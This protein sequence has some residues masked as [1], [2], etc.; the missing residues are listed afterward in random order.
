[1]ER[2]AFFREHGWL[3]VRG[4]VARARVEELER[5]LDAVVPPSYYARGLG[6]RV[7]ELPGI[8]RGSAELAAHARD[9]HLARVAAEALGA[10][11]LRL[12]QDSALVKAPADPARVEWHQDFTYL[13]FLEPASIATAR[14][15]LTPCTRESGCLRVLDGSHAWG[16]VGEVRALKSAAVDDA[17][18]LL[19]E[20]L[21]RRAAGAEVVIELEPGD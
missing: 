2:R 11:R 6:G 9:P 7:L 14:L 19:P 10:R 20:E 17:L 4:A 5:A 3:V 12:L 13:G 21:R 16:L 18:A 15:A 8:S 1:M